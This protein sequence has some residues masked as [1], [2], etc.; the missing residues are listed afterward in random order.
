MKKTIQFFELTNLTDDDRRLLLSS[1]FV[2]LVMSLVF[3]HLYTKKLLGSIFTNP[4]LVDMQSQSLKKDVYEVLVEQKNKVQKETDETKAYSDEDSAGSGG[5]TKKKGFHTDTPFR[6][7]LFGGIV[8]NIFESQSEKKET[9]EQ[10][11]AK[12]YEVEITELDSEDIIEKKEVKEIKETSKE[13]TAQKQEK[14]PTPKPNEKK[15]NQATSQE[16]KIPGNYRFKQD[17]MFR[18]TGDSAISIPTMK[19]AG[20][21]YFKKMLKQIEG[22]FAPP[23][24]GNFAYRD[25]AGYMVREGIVPGE[26]KVLFMLDD[27][28]K[29]L[30]VVL[31]SSKGQKIVD[32]ACLDAIRGQNFGPVPEE[33]KK[34]G[35]IFGINFIFPGRLNYR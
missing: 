4:S 26:I 22:S 11:E 34:N 12:S 16:T 15:G 19:L 17:F 13:K 35:L 2:V 27:S 20:F 33:I 30:D 6:E 18:W 28:G 25:A 9:D 10:E 21:E 23:G 3:A 32:N 14:N 29:V 8:G 24:G 31:K 5:I 1:C 7:F